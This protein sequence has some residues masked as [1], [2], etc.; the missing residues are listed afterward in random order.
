MHVRAVL[1]SSAL[2]T[3]ALPEGSHRKSGKASDL[4]QRAGNP[5][6]RRGRAWAS[7]KSAAVVRGQA[8]TQPGE[9]RTALTFQTLGPPVLGALRPHRLRPPLTCCG[10]EGARTVRCGERRAA[11]PPGAQRRLTH[12]GGDCDARKPWPS[13]HSTAPGSQAPSACR[14]T[15]PGRRGPALRGRPRPPPLRPAH[16][17]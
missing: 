16:A 14:P 11:C 13:A 4:S 8:D 1:A 12:S 15:T 17:L 7:Q 9:R 6:A 2:S 5:A 10:G 3:P